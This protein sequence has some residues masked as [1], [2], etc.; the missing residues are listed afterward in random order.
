M[1]RVLVV[2]SDPVEALTVAGVFRRH[3]FDIS[4]A[5]NGAAAMVQAG[6]AD[7]VVLGLEL[8]DF[9]GLELCR[10][11]R[12]HFDAPILGIA[13]RGTAIDIIA[14]LGAGLDAFLVQPYGLRELLARA[15]AI[16]RRV[17]IPEGEHA[18][19]LHGPL[20]IDART[21]EVTACGRPLRLTRK[22]FDLLHLLASQP[23]TL[24]SRQRIMSLVWRDD[25][26]GSSRT[27]DTHVSSVRG[28][29][30]DPA[31]I[32]T[33]RGVGFRI[34]YQQPVRPAPVHRISESLTF[35]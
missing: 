14:G 1:V 23:G 18:V 6:E 8:P 20:R 32:T 22:E 9:D 30:G 2:Q 19:V 7:L 11:I 5:A 33:V 3:G 16:L 21:R 10:Q 26:A 17:L 25:W 34:G 31:A 12:R 28:K 27:I 29:I 15:D 13:A 24:F 4:T 35:S